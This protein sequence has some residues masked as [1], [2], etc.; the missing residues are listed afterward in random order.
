MNILP[1]LRE[2]L[3]LEEVPF[4]KMAQKEHDHFVRVMKEA[5]VQVHY[6][7]DLVLQSL[8]SRE[9]VYRLVDDFISQAAI[10]SPG[11]Q[12]NSLQER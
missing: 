10:K 2:S 4:L 5:G 3:L 12:G 7:K 1:Q 6:L 9:I 11:S 8:T